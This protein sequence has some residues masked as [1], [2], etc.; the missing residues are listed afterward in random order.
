MGIKKAQMFF[1]FCQVCHL[2]TIDTFPEEKVK[3]IVNEH[4]TV[5]GHWKAV[6]YTVAR[7]RR[8]MQKMLNLVLETSRNPFY[9]R[10]ER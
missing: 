4:E 5:R 1:A 10:K 7:N 6:T 2:M 9:G 8:K 3:E